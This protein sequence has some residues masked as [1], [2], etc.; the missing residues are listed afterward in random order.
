[1]KRFFPTFLLLMLLS[2]CSSVML[3]GRKQLNLV[4]DSEITAM[5]FAQYKT[6]MH[7]TPIASSK[8]QA[9]MVKKVGQRVASAVE[10]YMRSKGMESQL[11][12][13]EWEFNLVKGNQANAFCMPG[14]KVAV[15]EGILPY[16]KT[17][18]GLAV[19]LGHEIAHAIARHASERLSQQM[20]IE[21]GAN[22]TGVLLMDKSLA[23]KQSVGA[24]YGIGAKVGVALPNSRKQELEADRLGLI[25]MAMAGYNPK[26]AIPFWQRMSQ[27][28]GDSSDFLSTHPSGSK[29]IAQIQKYLPEALRYYRK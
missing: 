2:G 11:K 4:S 10:K 20:L 5:S 8:S 29:R 7:S 6:F 13:F 24:L 1:M 26:E 27:G 17:E 18:A 22:L 3:T 19:V 12:G 23:V 21:Y 16:T 9:M 14:G 28:G 15:Y 25:F